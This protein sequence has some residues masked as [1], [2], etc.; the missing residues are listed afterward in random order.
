MGGNQT[1]WNA[2]RSL[3]Q[4]SELAAATDIKKLKALNTAFSEI[5]FYGQV[6]S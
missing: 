2:M 6:S 4:V 5:N 3:L 1:R